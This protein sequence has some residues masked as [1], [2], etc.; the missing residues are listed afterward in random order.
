MRILFLSYGII[1]FDGRLIEL[2]NVAKKLGD[3]TLVCCSSM[4]ESTNFERIVKVGKHKYLGAYLY[5][6]FIIKSIIN[7]L[8]IKNIDI[9]FVDNYFAAI[10][11]FIIKRFCKIKFIIQDV[12]E[13]YFIEDMKSWRGRLLF[14]YEVKLM[15]IANVVLCAN[16]QRAEI[17]YNHY[18]LDHKPLVFE[19]IRFFIG[20]YDK[21]E[22][23]NKYASM[24]RYKINIISTGGVS[25]I[26][27]TDRLIKAMKELPDQYGLYIV[28]GGNEDDIKLTNEIIRE[29][30]LKNVYLIDKVP[31][32]ELR[33][34]VQQCDIGIVNYHKNDLNNQY[35]ASGKVYEYLSEGL[36]IV[37]TE[38]I[39]L[40]EFC[41]KTN[42]G[43]ADDNFY[44]GILKVG[45]NLSKY[46]AAVKSFIKNIS[47]DDYNKN[48]AKKIEKLFYESENHVK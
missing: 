24:F 48:M 10:T 27:G 5:I 40:K 30:G 11:A 9:L 33:Y 7:A 25:I 42:T 14:R 28:G 22:M 43:V 41:A 12:R 17:M 15:R 37:T 31:L 35:C 46:K 20:D 16:N 2:Y 1:D 3:V 32:S 34:I 6:S 29:L 21:K 4:R 26:R 36:P 23:I 39:P 13:L 44:N 19:N 38:N 8:R 45:E 18:K 47:V